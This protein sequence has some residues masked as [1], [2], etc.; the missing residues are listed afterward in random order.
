MKLL[1]RT[2]VS[3]LS[4]RP[5]LDRLVQAISTETG[6]TYLESLTVFQDHLEGFQPRERVTVGHVLGSM[7]VEQAEPMVRLLE[8]H[9]QAVKRTLDGAFRSPQQPTGYA[10][11]VA[12]Q[13]PQA[14]TVDSEGR[15]LI[16]DGFDFGVLASPEGR[17][18]RLARARAVTP[19][20]YTG[21]DGAA[22]FHR[23]DR[24]ALETGWDMLATLEHRAAVQRA[25]EQGR[26]EAARLAEPIERTS[27]LRA[28]RRSLDARLHEL[29]KLLLDAQEKAKSDREQGRE[30]ALLRLRIGNLHTERADLL[31][32]RDTVTGDEKIELDSI[33]GFKFVLDAPPVPADASTEHAA[34][35]AD[36]QKIMLDEGWLP[37]RLREA[38]DTA[39]ERHRDARP[40]K[41]LL[42]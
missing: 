31:V 19:G 2:A 22:R 21:E 3:L 10:A 14:P 39:Y 9:Q 17:E 41:L 1:D 13:A 28:E 29:D 40:S 16:A 4:D 35:L 8:V 34:I 23:E 33:P 11:A 38:I 7:G 15:V 24:S 20:Q 30:A 36:A 12:G 42:A 32:K 26:K 27:K 25:R 37:E 6:M 5:E 18:R